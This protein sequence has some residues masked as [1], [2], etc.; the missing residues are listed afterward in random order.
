[1]VHFMSYE[2]T[3]SRVIVQRFESFHPRP[4]QDAEVDDSWPLTGSHRPTL[5]FADDNQS[6]SDVC[7][8]RHDVEDTVDHDEDVF[9][10]PSPVAVAVGQF[11]Q[12]VD[13][14]D[15]RPGTFRSPS[16]IDC[17]RDGRLAIVDSDSGVVQIFARNGDCLSSF[18][19]VGARSACFI[20]DAAR[21]DSLAVVTNNGVSICDETGRV[22]KH[23]PVGADIVAVAALRHGGGVFVAAH[24]NRLTICDRY[25]PSALLR[26][27]GTVRPFS[28]PIGHPGTQFG[29]I[30]ALATTATPRVYVVDAA[31]VLAVDI[32]SG[33]LLQTV[34]AAETRLLRQPSAVAVD[35]VTG[36]VFVLDATTRRVLQFEADGGRYRCVA[37]LPDDG[38][39]CVALAAGPRG[40]GGHQIVY[41]VCCG[42][43]SAQVHMYQI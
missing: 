24:R 31:A 26:S 33:T 16:S 20:A 14:P 7:C 40:P 8:D 43:G 38:S 11:G 39:K 35:L 13:A 9:V 36:G 2:T 30:V 17:A 10:D 3:G 21:G 25:Q 15:G 23:L 41:L 22:D 27:L 19:V 18:P 28:A 4:L 34:P 12:Y 42:Y 32:D 37:A 1:M 29:H 6:I 5:R